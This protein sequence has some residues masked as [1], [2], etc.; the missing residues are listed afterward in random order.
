MRYEEY[1]GV[2]SDGIPKVGDKCT[3]HLFSDANPCQVIRVSA[4][5]KTMWIKE[6]E[7][8]HDKSK[9]GGM[10]HQNW[11]IHEN[12]F[13]GDEMRITKRKDGQWRES[14]SNCYVALSQWKKYYDWEF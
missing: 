1:A 12:K 4:S 7:T 11:L 6:N 5:G 8:E 3:M 10:G 13:I 9:E 14:G 2:G